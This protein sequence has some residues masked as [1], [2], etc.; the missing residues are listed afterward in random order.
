[1]GIFGTLGKIVGGVANAA[2]GGIAGSIIGGVGGLLDGGPTNATQAQQ[3]GTQS[4][5]TQ[6]GFDPNSQAYID[7]M[8]QQSQEA[9]QRASQG[10][11]TPGINDWTQQSA[12][13]AQTQMG[14]GGDMFGFGQGLANQ[15]LPG[16][17]QTGAQ[18]MEGFMNPYQQQVIG[19]MND[20]FAREQLMQANQ[21]SDQAQGAGAWGGSRSGVAEG[22][23]RSRAG[24][25]HNLSISQM[26]SNQFNQ[27]MG[28]LQNQR[29]QHQ[30]M[31]GL[32]G[33]FGAQGAGI[34]GQGAGLLGQQ[35]EYARQVQQNQMRDQLFADQQAQQ[36]LQGGLG[37]MGTFSDTSGQQNQ[38]GTAGTPAE[39]WWKRAAGGALAGYG[40]GD[41]LFPGGGYDPGTWD[42]PNPLSPD[43]VEGPY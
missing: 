26:L 8:R 7:M 13:G 15:A 18:G 38:S 24:A 9:A 29:G 5:N 30:N 14:M 33:Q 3:G 40:I 43:S 11:Y 34:M 31:L 2:T 36:L 12:G 21:L 22:I 19:G 27:N 4:G 20:Q 17:M 6:T 25:D 28:Y 32:A 1:M 39:P 41:T 16:A 10:G 42:N 23:M 37:P 35:G